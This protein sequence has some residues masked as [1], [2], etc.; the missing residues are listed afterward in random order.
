MELGYWFLVSGGG[1]DEVMVMGVVVVVGNCGVVV[2]GM[3][4]VDRVTIL[5]VV[6]LLY[7]SVLLGRGGYGGAIVVVGFE[8]LWLWWP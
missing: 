2:V 6:G 7:L 4:A 3:T 1:G 5:I 8:W